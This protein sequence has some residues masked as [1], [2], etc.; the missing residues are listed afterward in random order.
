MIQLFWGRVGVILNLPVLLV[1]VSLP[2][3]QAATQWCGG[4]FQLVSSPC[5]NRANT[6][7]VGQA[8]SSCLVSD[9]SDESWSHD[10]FE[11]PVTT[12]LG[13][14]SVLEEG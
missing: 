13:R 10:G 8:Q 5:S 2:S 6:S 11:S 9:G 1:L 7:L 3:F 14:L 12:D 4:T